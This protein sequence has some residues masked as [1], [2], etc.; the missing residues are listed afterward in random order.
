MGRVGDKSVSSLIRAYGD[1]NPAKVVSQSA[2]ILK[3]EKEKMREEEEETR[4]KYNMGGMFLGETFDTLKD[5]REAQQGGFEGGF[6]NFIFNPEKGADAQAEGK[7]KIEDLE[8]KLEKDPN[9]IDLQAEYSNATSLFPEAQKKRFANRLEKDMEMSGLLGIDVNEWRSMSRKDKRIAKREYR[10]DKRNERREDRRD[11]RR[12]RKTDKIERK[13]FPEGFDSK[14]PVGLDDEAFD[15]NI[16]DSGFYKDNLETFDVD[17]PEKP[18]KINLDNPLIQD[19]D[20]IEDEKKITTDILTEPDLSTIQE[21]TGGNIDDN[22]I[23]DTTNKQRVDRT[24]ELLESG[25]SN[26]ENF[27]GPGNQEGINENILQG[28]D[29]PSFLG[30]PNPNKDSMNIFD[31]YPIDSTIVGLDERGSTMDYKYGVDDINSGS[32]ALPMPTAIDMNPESGALPM[33]NNIDNEISITPFES[34]DNTIPSDTVGD[35]I[36]S[37]DFSVDELTNLFME[38]YNQDMTNIGSGGGETSSGGGG[39][40]EGGD[41]A[42][43]AAS[44]GSLLGNQGDEDMSSQE[45]LVSQLPNLIKLFTS[46][47]G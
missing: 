19:K 7:K 30:E 34:F 8:N 28:Q 14:I 5:F 38:G 11:R 43:V 23:N 44:I 25:E 10:Q 41:W 18:V 40:M 20:L 4:A 1:V 21:S 33:P 22:I 31:A 36:N 35:V 2:N 37:E 12:E 32:G 6:F 17:I 27:L 45:K 29:V 24:F 9:N 42:G 13:H 16:D 47:G 46:F 39:R 3:Y 15:M 26:Q